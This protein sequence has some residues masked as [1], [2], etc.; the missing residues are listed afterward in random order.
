MPRAPSRH[1]HRPPL[2]AGPPHGAARSIALPH[3]P[4]TVSPRSTRNASRSSRGSPHD[5]SRLG[6]GCRYPGGCRGSPGSPP[7]RTAP[8]AAGPARLLNSPVPAWGWALAPRPPQ[9]LPAEPLCTNVLAPKFSGRGGQNEG[10]ALCSPKN[11]VYGG[12]R[13]S[14]WIVP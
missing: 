9:L 10:F 14:S 13:M 7:A 1:I 12:K 2:T 6:H 5:P 8:G 11:E 4:L 3:R